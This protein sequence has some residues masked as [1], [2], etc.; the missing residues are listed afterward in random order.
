MKYKNV[1][2]VAPLANLCQAGC[3]KCVF[4]G[5]G[6]EID[7]DYVMSVRNRGCGKSWEELRWFIVAEPTGETWQ[8][9]K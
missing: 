3:R 7:E 9:F 6:E 5:K 2:C 8:V 4:D 1:R